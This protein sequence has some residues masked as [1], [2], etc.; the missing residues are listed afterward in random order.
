MQ[1]I[2]V[3][4]HIFIDQMGKGQNGGGKRR[5][6]VGREG[7]YRIKFSKSFVSSTISEG[8]AEEGKELQEESRIERR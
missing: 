5:V 3:P 7:K 2:Y 4:S 8:G 6:G 1:P